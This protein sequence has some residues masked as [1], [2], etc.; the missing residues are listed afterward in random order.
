MPVLTLENIVKTF[1]EDGRVIKVLDGISL[2]VGDEF[3]AMLGPS[4]CGKT[5]LLRIIAGVE[6]PDSGKVVFHQEDAR[7][8]FVFQF[9]T[10]LPWAT[11]LENITTPLIAN[12]VSKE[13][14]RE[15]SRKYLSLVGLQN[16]EDFYP[17]ELSGGMKQRVNLA[18]ALAVEPTLLLTDEPFS[19]LDP[20]TAESLRTEIIDL[21]RLG[22]TSVKAI[23]TV[24]HSV[25]E[26]IFMADRIVI[27]TPRPAKIAG[28][29]EVGIPRPR[30]RRSPEFQQLEDKVYEI[31]SR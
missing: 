9:P 12:G 7:V 14:A 28:I 23:I 18:R 10:L 19:H 24:T 21:W 15:K 13:E 11:V 5:V 25:D 16:F 1:R 8:G 29:M 26:A 2:E 30:D 3:I 31:L 22:V 6:R 20:L 17:R 27:L 4:G